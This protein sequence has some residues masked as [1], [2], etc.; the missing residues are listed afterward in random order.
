LS[1]F[2][3]ASDTLSKRHAARDNTEPRDPQAVVPRA[4]GKKKLADGF[5]YPM[6][7]ETRAIGIAPRG[8]D[9]LLRTR[10]REARSA[11][12]LAGQVP[13]KRDIRNPSRKIRGAAPGENGSTLSRVS[14]QV[15][16]L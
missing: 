8:A 11:G 7:S 10:F 3:F 5:S 6:V 14:P 1:S 16:K 15:K 13:R 9:Q 12:R 4:A 2:G